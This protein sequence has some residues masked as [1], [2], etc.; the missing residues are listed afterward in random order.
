[1]KPPLWIRS[2]ALLLLAILVPGD[3]AA[4]VQRPLDAA[5]VH[6]R[7]LKHGI[8]HGVRVTLTDNTEINGVLT[9]LGEED[10]SIRPAG[11]GIPRD[12]APRTLAY[13]LVTGVHGARMSTGAK[14]A[15]GVGIGVAACAIAIGVAL[16]R[17]HMGPIFPSKL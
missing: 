13:S 3:L 7:L 15:I 17:W 14:I 1:M 5:G 10:F 11:H 12:A 8:G 6:S 2:A 4:A 16:A 9:A